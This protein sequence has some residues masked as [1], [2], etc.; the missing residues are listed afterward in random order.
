MDNNIYDVNKKEKPKKDYKGLK[1][2]FI[3]IFIIYTLF[4]SIGTFIVG[5]KTSYSR[6]F[7][8][9]SGS[10]NMQNP[11]FHASAYGIA[12]FITQ[13]IYKI[14]NVIVEFSVF[15]VNGTKV[16]S[17]KV[18]VVDGVASFEKDFATGELK[19]RLNE[20]TI[21]VI[22][23]DIASKT[24]LIITTSIMVAFASGLVTYIIVT[25]IKKINRGNI[26]NNYNR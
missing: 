16:Y 6:G 21:K 26:N 25:I 20:V 22:E 23:K 9:S 17:E 8:H 4:F 15:D 12:E 18:L 14:E 1:N 7:S 5:R 13:G 24:P 19:Y 10:F 11:T 2:F 3:V